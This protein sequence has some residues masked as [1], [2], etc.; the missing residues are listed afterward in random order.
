MQQEDDLRSL[1]NIIQFIRAVSCLF[2]LLNV[3][4]FCYEWFSA[5]GLTAPVADRILLGFQRM[6]ALFSYSVTTKLCAF[7]LLALSCYGTKSV[8]DENISRRDIAVTGAVG[9]LLFFFNDF[10][11]FLPFGSGVRFWSY[12]LTLVAGYLCL[13][14]TGV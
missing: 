5:H 1:E 11:R 2:L 8:R 9:L 4:W 14:A 6:T 13:L 12:S 10:L 7:V 3:Y